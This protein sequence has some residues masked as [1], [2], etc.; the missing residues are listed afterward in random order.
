[1]FSAIGCAAPPTNQSFAVSVYD[2]QRVLSDMRA[3]PRPLT[4]P[5]V[6]LGGLGD[7]GF[8]AN[9]LR[10]EFRK[11]TGDERVVG[12]SFLFCGDFDDCRKRVIEAVDKAFPSDDPTW[13]TEVDVIGV[14]MGGLVG[15]YAAVPSHDPERPRRLRIA[16]LFTIG[17]P[18]RGAAWAVLPAVNG[19]HRAM[20]QDS[21]FLRGLSEAEAAGGGYEIYPYVRLGDAIVGATNAAPHG[22]SP[23]WVPG[24]ALQD[25]H[26]MAS[27]DARIVADVARRLRGETPF[28]TDP[29]QP[30]PPGEGGPPPR[31]ASP[32]PAAHASGPSASGTTF[33]FR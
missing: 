3:R 2:A 26:L 11:V 19:M 33:A 20:R 5:L 31:P 13:T 21:P 32:A 28:T 27:L 6:I 30:L 15:R 18:H 14:S 23:W 24:E 7:P 9:N 1:M 12:V 4:R 29:P 16:R 10:S 22:R 17:T 8:A 25:S